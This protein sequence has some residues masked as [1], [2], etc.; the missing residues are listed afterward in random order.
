MDCDFTVLYKQYNDG[1]GALFWD[2]VY[3]HEDF[4]DQHRECRSILEICS[5]PGFIGWGIAHA[6]G[7]KEVHFGDIH[8]PVN[9]DLA[10][11]AKFNNVDYTFHL[12]DGFKSYNG[13]KVDLIMVSPPFFTKIEEFESFQKNDADLLTQDQV[14]N[15][16]RRWLD[17]DMKLHKNVLSN[18]SKYLTEKGRI[19]V[20][21]DKKHI[22]K[23]MLDAEAKN[24]THI[25]HKEF[26]V[27]EKPHWQSYIRTYYI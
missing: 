27:K 17:L 13:P 20:L 12:S 26:D 4:L 6:L 11:T 1:C 24:Y 8:E 18:F 19:V 3:N 9:I 25:T 15:H 5:G 16:K 7:I 22:D 23:D 14:E 10:K 21:A 2:A